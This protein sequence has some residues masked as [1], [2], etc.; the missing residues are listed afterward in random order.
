MCS[1]L[2][3]DCVLL[4]LLLLLLSR[5]LEG[6]YIVEVGHNAYLPC[7]YTLPTSGNPV[8]VCWGK[9]P[10]P[11]FECSV[12]VL[13]TDERKVTSQLSNRYQ[14]K[15]NLYKGDVSLTI[16]SVTLADSGTYCCRIQFPGLMNDKKINL[17]LV[18]K[19]AEVTTAPTLQGDLTTAL[20]R[21]LATEENG[22]AETQTLETFHDKN[23]TRT[24]ILDSDLQE[25]SGI[26]TRRDVYIGAG[27]S[28]GLTLALIVG[29]I[30][31]KWY[32]HKKEELKN[33]RLISLANI[34]SSGLANAVAGGMRSEENIYTIEENIYET[35]DPNEYYC[36]VSNWQQS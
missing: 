34:P 29:A 27:I 24:F 7:S 23:Q 21:M 36:Y 26:T 3:V 1:H 8:P 30:I 16:R 9:G 14:L 18:I 13:K 5:T 25:D 33:S 28:G 2:S 19:S 32:S 35:E 6:A 15:G 17:E 20:S 31:L 22:T 10:C 12:T 11:V 4:L